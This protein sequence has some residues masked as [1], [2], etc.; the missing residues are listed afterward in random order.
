LYAESFKG[1]DHLRQ[2][3]EDAQALIKTVFAA[4]SVQ[5]TSFSTKA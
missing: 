2:I 5:P 4:A 1:R 3:Q